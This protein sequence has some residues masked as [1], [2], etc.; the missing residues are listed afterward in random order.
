MSDGDEGLDQMGAFRCLYIYERAI[1]ASGLGHAPGSSLG[2]P[3]PSG[4]IRVLSPSLLLA[5]I[6]Y[7][8][9]LDGEVTAV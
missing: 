5:E 2:T 7:A 1:L 3:S 8:G 4:L 9:R 6:L